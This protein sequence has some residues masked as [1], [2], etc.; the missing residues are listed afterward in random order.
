VIASG[1]LS[2][3]RRLSGAC[4]PFLPWTQLA[5]F[6]SC[7]PPLSRSAV[8]KSV[9]IPGEPA[10]RRHRGVDRHRRPPEGCSLRFS[11]SACHPRAAA[12]WPPTMAFCYL[13]V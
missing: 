1:L 4:W 12:W 3:M 11:Y 9:G 2:E 7:R 8:T 5:R 10:G 13:R 6:F